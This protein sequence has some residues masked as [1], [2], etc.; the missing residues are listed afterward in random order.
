MTNTGSADLTITDIA[1]LAFPFSFDGGTCFTTPT[2]L[3]PSES[4]SI[5]VTFAPGAVSGT[6]LDSFDIVSNAA[7]SPDTVTV[8]GV[9]GAA[10]AIP[11]LG[12]N[13]LVLLM[14]IM[15]AIGGLVMRRQA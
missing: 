11:T 14:L 10:V 3:A 1:D 15:V 2:T 12:R 7:S 5:S 6:F 13:G 8:Q 9:A 4:C